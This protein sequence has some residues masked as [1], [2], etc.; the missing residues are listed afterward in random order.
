MRSSKL[1][2]HQWRHS[3]T[4][5][6]PAV[7][8]N[9]SRAGTVVSFTKQD[10]A[11]DVLNSCHCIHQVSSTYSTQRVVWHLIGCCLVGFIKKFSWWVFIYWS[12]TNGSRGTVGGRAGHAAV[13]IKSL[14]FRCVWMMEQMMWSEQKTAVSFR[15]KHSLHNL[16][17]FLNKAKTSH[18]F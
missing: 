5:P 8:S 15:G 12:G 10:A 16:L 3:L 17:C 13:C 1:M 7:G 9:Q 11:D 18:S 6:C 14:R 4:D 2:T